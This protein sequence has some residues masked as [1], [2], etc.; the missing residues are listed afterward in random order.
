[1]EYKTR[2]DIVLQIVTAIAVIALLLYVVFG[3]P[4]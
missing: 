1:M 3:P 4:L 2:S